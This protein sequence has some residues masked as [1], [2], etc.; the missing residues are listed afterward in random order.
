MDNSVETWE[1]SGKS[2]VARSVSSGSRILC[3]TVMTILSGA[4]ASAFEFLQFEYLL[5]PILRPDASSMWMRGAGWIALF[6]S[7]VAVSAEIIRPRLA[8]CSRRGC[9]L[10]L[11]TGA[12]VGALLLVIVP[13]PGPKVQGDWQVEIM[14]T[15]RMNPAAKSHEVWLRRIALGERTLSL[16]ELSASASWS[17]ADQALV[18]NT[19]E[20]GVARWSGF[21]PGPLE[22][23]F[24][25]HPWCGIVELTINGE[26]RQVDLYHDTHVPRTVSFPA[27]AGATRAGAFKTRLAQWA[28]LSFLVIVC[29][30]VLAGRGL[31]R[32]IAPPGRWALLQHG[33]VCA[34]VWF[35]YLLAFWPGAMTPDSVYQ[36]RQVLDLR[37]DNDHPFTHTLAI[38]LITRIWLSPAMVAMVQIAALSAVVGWGMVTL[39]RAGMPR[40]AGML[41]TG[42]IALSPA[43]A[44][45]AITLWK[46]VPYGILLAALT[47]FIVN[48]ARCGGEPLK[49]W[50]PCLALGVLAA[51]LS[52]LRHEGL[53]TG[54]ITLALLFVVFRGYRGGVL[55]GAAVALLLYV[56]T[57]QIVSRT[58][59]VRKARIGIETLM[60]HQIAAHWENGTYFAP[61]ER[62]LIA[63]LHPP[64]DRLAY[65]PYTTRHLLHGSFRWHVMEE[66]RAD[67]RRLFWATLRRN[68]KVNLRHQLE[69]SAFVRR[70][71]PS[72]S[73]K[74]DSTPIWMDRGT[75]RT[76]SK[77]DHGL[78]EQSFAPGLAQRLS[79]TWGLSA[80]RTF[81]VL[82]WRVPFWFYLGLASVVIAALRLRR[83][84][85]LLAAVPVLAHCATVTMLP[86]ANN[87]RY[88]F[89]V[90][91]SSLIL[92][93]LLFVV[94]RPTESE[95]VAVD[96][97]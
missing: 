93:G 47:V 3:L 42:L 55:V 89:G 32:A 67:V 70:I 7:T 60:F 97:C 79:T 58:L 65:S 20:G 19:P 90:Y 16:S 36:W 38:W 91:I 53:V 31:P 40:W 23:T 62:A 39:R 10:W 83:T 71:I 82:V 69:A 80:N 72:R 21:D 85:L 2:P 92:L 24:D 29:G 1:T 75:L 88:V 61:E 78:V 35:V 44:V 25:A 13:V 56:G 34:L 87:F 76:I 43:N 33:G 77:N 54:G 73:A 28:A 4:I 52:L 14:A 37:L 68:P 41:V 48:L 46:D 26:K 6:V 81:H 57:T 59:D 5:R 9:M 17:E 18:C 86:I 45:L 96:E 63:E 51:G 27:P 66:R 95:T 12:G 94:R 49:R 8:A 22:I 64:G 15:G 30:L 11:L 50:G 84:S 74:Y